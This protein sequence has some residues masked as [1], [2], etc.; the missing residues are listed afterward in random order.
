MQSIVALL[1]FAKSSY[2]YGWDYE[3]MAH[4]DHH[5]E[6]CGTSDQSPINIKYKNSVH[7]TSVCDQHTFNWTVDWTQSTWQVVNNGHSIVVIPVEQ[8]S[9]D[10]DSAI[11]GSDGN[12]YISLTSHEN[13]IGRLR[14]QFLPEHSPHSEFCLHS[15]HF[16]WAQ[17]DDTGSEHL[18][19]DHQYPLEVHFV[20]YSWYVFIE[21]IFII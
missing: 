9:D 20:H 3:D 14:N 10:Y 13:S 4:W 19:D 18:I 15:F 12:K 11:I 21:S 17:E 1:L 7:D 2:G 6:Q 16:H 5:Y 8:V